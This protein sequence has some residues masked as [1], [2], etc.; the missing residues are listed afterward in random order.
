MQRSFPRRLLSVSVFAMAAVIASPDV[1]AFEGTVSR[2]T[3]D[4]AEV[5]S[6]F[7][8][9]AYPDQ[10]LFGD[11]HFHTEI[12]FDAGLIGTSLDMHDAFR[13]A[14]E[15]EILSNTGQRVQLIRPLDFLA[16]TEHA[17]MIGIATAIRSSDPRLLNDEWGRRVYDQFQS[18]QEGR[19]A[20]FGEII[21][22]ATVEGRNPTEGLG[23]DGDM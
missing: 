10:V 23:L 19:M 18:G 8:G 5:Y 20:A 4:G 9:R 16:I 11:L 3:V 17:E 7:A 6:P 15:E 22:I 2:Q 14:K 1:E 21:Q 13:I 12:S